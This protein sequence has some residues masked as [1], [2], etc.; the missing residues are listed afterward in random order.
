MGG[1]GS[2][3]GR[4]PIHGYGAIGGWMRA[5]GGCKADRWEI[6]RWDG[7]VI[8]WGYGELGFTEETYQRIKWP[9][10]RESKVYRYS[11]R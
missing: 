7:I 4:H 3:P 9:L 11:R 8:L 5:K 6:E 2:V 1:I 10:T